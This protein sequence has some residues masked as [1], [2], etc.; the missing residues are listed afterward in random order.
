MAGCARRRLQFLYL[1]LATGCSAHLFVQLLLRPRHTN[2]VVGLWCQNRRCSHENLEDRTWAAENIRRELK[3]V[4]SCSMH[5]EVPFS[6]LCVSPVNLCMQIRCMSVSVAT[7][8]FCKK[9]ITLERLSSYLGRKL[10]PPSNFEIYF[11]VR[12][13]W[14][15]Q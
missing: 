12:L 6:T 1:Q 11:Q 4:I 9:Q 10:S 3:G 13:G 8:F 14:L 5:Y 7:A 2:A 15:K